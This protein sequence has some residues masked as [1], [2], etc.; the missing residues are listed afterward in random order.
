MKKEDLGK[1]WDLPEPLGLF[2][3]RLKWSL[4]A[5]WGVFEGSWGDLGAS[6]GGVL[7]PLGEVL[8]PLGAVSWGYVGAT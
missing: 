7:A 5:S 1:R 2:W 8:G 6:W 3:D 4:T